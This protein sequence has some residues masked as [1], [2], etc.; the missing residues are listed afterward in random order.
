MWPTELCTLLSAADPAARP[1]S[2]CCIFTLRVH[3]PNYYLL[4]PY[5]NSKTGPGPEIADLGFLDWRFMGLT[6]YRYTFLNWGYKQ[7]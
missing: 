2:F 3:V 5:N 1:A 6:L 7:L 4:W